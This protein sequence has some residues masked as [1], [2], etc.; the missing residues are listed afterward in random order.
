M[1]RTGAME[2]RSSAKSCSCTRPCF[3]PLVPLSNG[4]SLTPR[5]HELQ[6]RLTG[7]PSLGGI[8]VLGIDPGAMG[9]GLMRNA[10]WL[11]STLI[12]KVVLPLT[13]PLSTR[14]QNNGAVRTTTKS[15]TD[16][17]R[18]C[19]DT[20]ALGEKP[21]GVYLNG[22]AVKE[23]GAESRDRVKR[24][25]LWEDSVRLVGLGAGETALREWR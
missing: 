12:M 3:P 6:S 14:L 1:M 4:A 13:A 25:A 7:D 24:K 8:S 17:L 23:T 16:A 19:F 20:E 21:R 10:S 2:R 18:A 15:A 9:T 11:S 5:R 22:T